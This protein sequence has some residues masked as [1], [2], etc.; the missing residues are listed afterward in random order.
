MGWMEGTFTQPM[1]TPDG[2][3]VQPTGKSFKIPMCTI[4]R[5][6]D[7]LMEEEYLFWDNQTYMKQLGI[8]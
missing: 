1:K 7:G 2:K 3:V 4:G 6:K 8:G 5:W